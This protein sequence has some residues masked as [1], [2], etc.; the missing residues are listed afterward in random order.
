LLHGI[1]TDCDNSDDYKQEQEEAEM[2]IMMIMM[3]LITMFCVA[4]V[5][6]GRYGVRIPAA[7][8]EF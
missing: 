1:T 7:A 4:T 6:G 2:M 8:R 5:M 3:I